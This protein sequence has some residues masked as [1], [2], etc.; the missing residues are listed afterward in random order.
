MDMIS[1]PAEQ[2]AREL[3]AVLPR[4][5]R[6]VARELRTYDG[7]DTTLVQ[8]RV[9]AELADAPITLTA[10][11]RKREVSLQAASEHV[12]CLVERGWVE[13][14]PDP[15]DRRQSLLHITDAGLRRLTEVREHIA[16]QFTPIIGR[17]A[18]EDAEAIHQGLLAL[19]SLLF[20]DDSR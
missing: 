18:N 1:T 15:S 6:I 11:A 8:M 5:N 7:S 20:D 9:L 3:L 2:I 13:R 12:H 16:D 19:R 10:L 14:R 4:L 17:L